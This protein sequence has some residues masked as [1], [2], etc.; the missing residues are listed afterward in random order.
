MAKIGS[1]RLARQGLVTVGPRRPPFANGVTTG[2]EKPCQAKPRAEAGHSTY[3]H[4]PCALVVFFSYGGGVAQPQ[5][6]AVHGPAAT[7]T[8]RNR[9]NTQCWQARFRTL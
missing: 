8:A 2:S 3:H 7:H 1:V 5:R 9:A 6:R 4:G